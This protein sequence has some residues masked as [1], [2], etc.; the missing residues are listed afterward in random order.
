MPANGLV[1]IVAQAMADDWNHLDSRMQAVFRDMARRALA[2][3]VDPTPEMTDA[4]V[5]AAEHDP[6]GGVQ[7]IWRAM[8][9]AG[10]SGEQG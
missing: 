3:A 5:D 10:L 4:G 6:G 1:D 8:L 9:L 2:A 7:G